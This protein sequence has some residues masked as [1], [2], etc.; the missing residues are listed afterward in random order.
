MAS[1]PVGLKRKLSQTSTQ[2]QSSSRI[3]IDLADDDDD[4]DVIPIP[5]PAKRQKSGTPV[6]NDGSEGQLDRLRGHNYENASGDAQKTRAEPGPPSTPVT[7]RVQPDG[8]TSIVNGTRS[9]QKRSPWGK[10]SKYS[11]PNGQMPALS[12]ETAPMAAGSSM[13]EPKTQVSQAVSPLLDKVNPARHVHRPESPSAAAHKSRANRSQSQEKD[14]NG[15]AQRSKSPSPAHNK[16]AKPSGPLGESIG[17]HTERS[18]SP[19]AAHQKWVNSSQADLNGRAERSKSPFPAQK[20]RTKSS[21]RLVEDIHRFRLSTTSESPASITKLSPSTPPLKNTDAKIPLTGSKDD[22]RPHSQRVVPVDIP[23]RPSPDIQVLGTRWSYTSPNPQ[24][25]TPLNSLHSVS[26]TTSE[27]SRSNIDVVAPSSPNLLA[28]FQQKLPKKTDK[29]AVLEKLKQSTAFAKEHPQEVQRHFGQTG[30]SSEYGTKEDHQREQKATSK[31]MKK[32]AARGLIDLNP[33]DSLSDFMDHLSLGREVIHPAQSGRDILTN[34]FNEK[35]EPPIT[36]A[37]DINERRL[38][39]KFQ[40]TDRYIIR[41]GV[42]VA[43]PTTNHGCDC[44]DCHLS[45]CRCLAKSVPDEVGK[46]THKEQRRTYTRRPDGLVVISDDYLA[47]A[48]NPVGERF[49]ITE[50][51]EFCACGPD[52]WNRVV[53]KGRTVPL[54]IF[55]TAKCG[56]GVRSSQDIVKGQFIESYLGE[57]ITEDELLRREDIVEEDDPSYIYSLDW[58]ENAD[59]YHVDGKYFGTPMR[60]VNHSCNPNTKS[61][62]VQIHK[63]DKKVY[64]LAFFAIK[65]IKA[66]VEIRIDYWGAAAANFDEGDHDQSADGEL[67]EGLVRCRC[68]EKNCRK[69]LWP[70]SVKARRR[71]RRKVG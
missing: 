16:R 71:R 46:G 18:R 42:R 47:Q 69:T 48:L 15:H 20:K 12:V 17:R 23:I 37:N 26:P 43:S 65:D 8:S 29:K 31:K 39:G 59:Q 13:S 9:K 4:D 32:K 64:Y 25:E 22:E 70:S 35:F 5:P 41:E 56:F 3:L 63:G 60:F 14:I 33:G 30:F 38:H 21:Q 24:C 2:Q 28:Q 7:S 51:N 55:Q 36:F 44:T 61:F 66:R 57:V 62:T 49:E 52:C 34:R 53:G 11:Y 1:G 45:S 67:A 19:S 6:T 10:L 50:C 58:F 27:P 40:F 54:E 68:G